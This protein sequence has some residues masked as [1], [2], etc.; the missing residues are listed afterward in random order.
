MGIRRLT[1]MGLAVLAT[2]VAMTGCEPPADTTTP[3]QEAETQSASPDIV[4]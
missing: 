1:L 2:L 3:Q 4:E